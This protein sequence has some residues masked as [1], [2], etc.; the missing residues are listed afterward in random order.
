MHLCHSLTSQT[1]ML[2]MYM[3]CFSTLSS[4]FPL[5]YISFL[6]CPPPLSRTALP[7]PFSPFYYSPPVLPLA[8]LSLALPLCLPADINAQARKLQRNRAKGTLTLPR[9]SNS[10][11]CRS[12]SETSLNQVG[13]RTE[14]SSGGLIVTIHGTVTN[15]C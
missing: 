9:S 2:T 7:L 11:F 8:L 1:Y 13:A 14:A 3:S 6:L 12:L 4:Y 10:S 15:P 5:L